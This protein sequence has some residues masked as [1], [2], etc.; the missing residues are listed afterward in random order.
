MRRDF[1][2][3]AVLC[4]LLDDAGLRYALTWD[5]GGTPRA[6]FR[7]AIEPVG[8]PA[9]FSAVVEEPVLRVTVDDLLRCEP[10]LEELLW[11][12]RLNASWMR[13]AVYYDR[14]RG[15]YSVAAA[16]YVGLGEH[17]TAAV[18]DVVL[19]LRD[20]ARWLRTGWWRRREHRSLMDGFLELQ[21]TRPRPIARNGVVP[22]IERALG[23]AG[24]HASHLE[25]STF[26][27]EVGELH[28]RLLTVRALS[29]WTLPPV[30]VGLDV[31]AGLQELN[32]EL[33]AGW[34]WIDEEAGHVGWGLG[35]P[36]A[37]TTL[38]VPLAHWIVHSARVCT[39][40]LDRLLRGV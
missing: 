15:G 32:R 19:T 4:R 23:E 7:F 6:G 37:W 5:D 18:R 9:R 35:L 14:A 28:E 17:A 16:A 20:A 36:L 34:C 30:P 21:W 10:A 27:V 22:E 39:A 25:R 33:T 12:N 13:G 11:L 1:R 31:L 3:E 38:D 2:A 40:R 26:R 8:E 24:L 29:R